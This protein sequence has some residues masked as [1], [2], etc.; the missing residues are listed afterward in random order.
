MFKLGSFE[1]FLNS[2]LLFFFVVGSHL[3]VSW[4]SFWGV[5][6]IWTHFTFFKMGK[7]YSKEIPGRF[8]S[9]F[10]PLKMYHLKRKGSSS[11]QDF[12]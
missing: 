4:P 5:G 6:F 2:K 1:V 7:I 10:C 11:N 12:F 3:V 9:E 8:N